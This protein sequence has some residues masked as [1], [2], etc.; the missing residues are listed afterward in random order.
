MLNKVVAMIKLIRLDFPD[1]TLANQSNGY[2]DHNFTDKLDKSTNRLLVEQTQS[3]L[4]PN[5]DSLTTNNLTS[6]NT[7]EKFE[8]SG[9]VPLDNTDKILSHNFLRN[10]S[11]LQEMTLL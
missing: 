7:E 11:V 5:K 10:V 1:L 8:T 9:C 4:L 3:P 6:I 2:L